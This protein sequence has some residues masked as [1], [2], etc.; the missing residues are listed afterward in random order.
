MLLQQIVLHNL[1]SEMYVFTDL[2]HGALP[3]TNW[4][5]FLYQRVVACDIC[6]VSTT[7]P[8]CPDRVAKALPPQ[9]CC[10]F[11]SVVHLE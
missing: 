4:D 11:V 8:I 5:A 7:E 3:D 10:C 1:T 6:E 2:S 9:G